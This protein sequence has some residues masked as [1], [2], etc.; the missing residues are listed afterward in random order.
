MT[1]AKESLERIANLLNNA[2]QLP[3]LDVAQPT[4]FEIT[5]YPHLENVSS[6]VLAFLLYDFRRDG[7]LRQFQSCLIAP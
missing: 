3:K 5:G 6:N 2:K 7:K 4:F 1:R